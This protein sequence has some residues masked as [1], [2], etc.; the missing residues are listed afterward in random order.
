MAEIH[1][2]AIVD[3]SAVIADDVKIGPYSI[4]EPDV[5]IGSGCVLRANS[6]VRRFTEMGQNNTVDSFVVLGGIPQ[7]YKF[8]PAQE[9]YLRIGDD[10][11]F[12][13]GVT[14]N[15]AT[16]VKEA[17]VVG[18][19]TFW[20]SN[21][22]AG[23]NATIGDDVVLVN[24]TLVAGHATVGDRVIL[25][26]NGGVHQFCWVGEGVMVQGGGRIAMHIPP[27]VLCA[28]LNT[29]VSLNS[30][31]LRRCEDISKEDI[32]Q[33]KEAFNIVYRSGFDKEN[34]LAEMEKCTEWGKAAGKFRDFVKAVYTAE[35]PFDRG[36]CP[37]RARRKGRGK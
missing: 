13:E 10:N 9:T 25:P 6:I 29:I 12:R 18:N 8:D 21:S 17:T 28:D 31:G 7:D 5:K 11:V 22:H 26:A 1:P 14:I 15:R 35:P 19:R 32:K 20:F 4:V 34:V 2:T 27:Y 37:H 30:V 36:L 23:H 24:G 16:G 3:D 33:I